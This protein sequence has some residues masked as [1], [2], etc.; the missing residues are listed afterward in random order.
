[1]PR[2][3]MTGIAVVFIGLAANAHDS[4][5]KWDAWFARQN[6]MRGGSC[7]KLSHAHVIQD[8]DW[9]TW[10]K[11]DYEVR[12]NDRWYIV[13]EW[14]MLKPADPNPTGHAILW[15]DNIGGFINIYCFIPSWET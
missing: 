6:N 10:G 12:I 1:M 4:E 13:E 2:T 11:D 9:K 8:E 14:Q 5:G 3:I 7:C 15:Y